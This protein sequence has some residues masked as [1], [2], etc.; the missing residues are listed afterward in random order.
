MEKNF[1]SE[2]DKVVL[3][4]VAKYLKSYNIRSGVIQVEYDYYHNPERF[5]RNLSNFSNEWS[6]EI[7]DF[8]RPYL[9]EIIEKTAYFPK[10]QLQTILQ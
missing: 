8:F 4:K 10:L 6:V 2:E 7:P 1:I 5:I 3:R 9:G